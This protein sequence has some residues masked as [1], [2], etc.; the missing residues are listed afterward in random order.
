MLFL[1]MVKF[2]VRLEKAPG[3][4]GWT[5]FEVPKSAIQKLKAGATQSFRVKGT[6]DSHPIERA[7]I[8]P[9]GNGRFL[10]PFNASMRKGTGK[11][12][13][14]SVVVS[15]TLDLKQPA[16]SR[17]LLECLK[18]DANANAQFKSLSKGIQQYYSKWIE[19]AKTPHTK[20]KRL[21]VFLQALEQKLNFVDMMQL[22]K[23]YIGEP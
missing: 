22:Y 16:L 18:D 19:D 17:E 3:K 8:M 6:L 20:T 14:D 15:F 9:I 21:V 1:S 10:M 11:Q 13:G 2:K 4:G 23:N 7:S 5:Y 12:Q